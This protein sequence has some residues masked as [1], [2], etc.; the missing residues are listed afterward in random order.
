MSEP[1]LVQ[2]LCLETTFASLKD[3]SPMRPMHRRQRAH[4]VCGLLVEDDDSSRW[5]PSD[6][7]EGCQQL[8]ITSII[9]NLTFFQCFY[10][11]FSSVVWRPNYAF[12][13]KNVHMS[14]LLIRLFI[15]STINHGN[16]KLSIIF[17]SLPKKNEWQFLDIVIKNKAPICY[18][19]GN[20]EKELNHQREV[21]RILEEGSKFLKTRI[22]KMRKVTG[23]SVMFLH[24]W[25]P[26]NLWDVWWSPCSLC[27]FIWRRIDWL[28]MIL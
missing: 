28:C 14:F 15:Y 9:R 2:F 5:Q 12:I 4:K 11:A 7:D 17:L 13:T 25:E 22:R 23:L 10:V 19:I 26:S 21:A 27:S 20:K 1:I 16:G 18:N 8:I 6:Q 3:G 24:L